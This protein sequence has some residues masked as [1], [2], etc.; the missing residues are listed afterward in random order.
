MSFCKSAEFDDPLWLQQALSQLFQQPCLHR[1]EKVAQQHPTAV[2]L[3]VSN[4]LADGPALGRKMANK[5]PSGFRWGQTMVG[6]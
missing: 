6:D 3:I 2:P 5:K 1:N 4:Q